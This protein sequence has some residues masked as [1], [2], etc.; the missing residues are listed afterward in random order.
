MTDS[1]GLMDKYP[2]P[3]ERWIRTSKKLY[4]LPRSKMTDEEKEIKRL[5]NEDKRERGRKYQRTYYQNNKVELKEKARKNAK[6]HYKN[7]LYV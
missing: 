5:N 6:E 3:D 2:P 4:I 7:K 1:Y